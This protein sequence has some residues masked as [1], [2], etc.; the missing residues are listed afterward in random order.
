M[1]LS[2]MIAALCLTV[3]GSAFAYNQNFYQ[4]DEAE[5]KTKWQEVKQSFEELLNGGWEPHPVT[6]GGY[7]LKK[8]GKFILC[9]VMKT[10]SWKDAHSYCIALN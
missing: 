6:S 4:P 1:K 9:Q 2:A 8:D 3:P 10:S 5:P 7:L